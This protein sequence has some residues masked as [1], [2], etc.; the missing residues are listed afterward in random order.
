MSDQ[1]VASR[2]NPHALPPAP[3]SPS[4]LSCPRTRRLA[5]PSRGSRAACGRLR[6]AATERRVLTV[7]RV[8]LPDTTS[9]SSVHP[10]AALWVVSVFRPPGGARLCAF[11]S[12]C[13]PRHPF[14]FLLV[15]SVR[16][17]DPRV[18]WR[19]LAWRR[20]AAPRPRQHVR[21]GLVCLTGPG[22]AERRLVSPG[23]GFAVGASVLKRGLQR[24]G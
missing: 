24:A 3:R 14:E 13:P 2:G 11:V 20:G 1:C 21:S 7:V 15:L 22:D 10:L 6:P 17:R 23:F 19:V 16:E 4:P 5:V 18:R 8:R 12:V 9:R